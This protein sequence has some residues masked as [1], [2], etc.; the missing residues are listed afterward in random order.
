MFYRIMESIGKLLNAMN[1]QE[2]V[3]EK[4][5]KLQNQ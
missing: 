3:Y 5:S 4:I 1:I 2:K